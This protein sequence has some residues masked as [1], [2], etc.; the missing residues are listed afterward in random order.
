MTATA[1]TP[2]VSVLVRVRNERSALVE[3]C[4]RL[5]RQ[6]IRDP[7]EV[8]VVD[9]ESNDGSGDVARERGARVFTLP[10]HHFG[11]GVAL[12]LGIEVSRGGYITPL[13]A[14]AWPIQKMWLQR[15]VDVLDGDE[16][17]AAAYSRQQPGAA[18]TPKEWLRFAEF[19]D[20]S[21][22]VSSAD[23]RRAA[24][25]GGDVFDRC[26]Y[27]NAAGILRR[28]VV[29]RL[30]FRDLGYAEDRAFA[31][32]AMAAGH[33]IAYVADVGVEYERPYT[34]H[35]LFNVGTGSQ[36]GKRLVLDLAVDQVGRP[37]G[38]SELGRRLGQVARRPV[39]LPLR[40]AQSLVRDGA[41][42]RR[43]RQFEVASTGT[44][45]GMLFGELRWR[46]HRDTTGHDPARLV[47]AR[48]ALRHPEGES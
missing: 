9:N 26:R 33:A 10:R 34:F 20:T 8:V 45:L 39:M 1:A 43:A 36:I 19:G 13:S 41:A 29:T 4:D 25:S 2:R 3:L 47:A 37:V 40:V 22:V 44:T 23:L 7:W 15:L 46:H 31:L 21:H 30:P 24:S 28:D 35:A 6:V 12:N 32:D 18:A 27:S 42:G 14:H 38:R 5:D 48:A 11:Y 17:L 16:R